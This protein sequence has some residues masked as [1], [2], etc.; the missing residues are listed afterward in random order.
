MPKTH[1][2]D[3][4]VGSD[5]GGGAERGERLRWNGGIDTYDGQSDT[6]TCDLVA[7]IGRREQ[8]QQVRAD[9]AI[10]ESLIETGTIEQHPPKGLGK[11][12]D[13]LHR[14]EHRADSR[15]SVRVGKAVCRRGQNG[16]RRVRS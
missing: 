14:R 2:A 11:A 7:M 3:I 8:V 9:G 4:T 15:S 1:L 6:A 12:T 13:E 5:R 16:L 10:G